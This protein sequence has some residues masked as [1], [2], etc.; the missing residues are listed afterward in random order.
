[1][2]DAIFKQCLDA[3]QSEIQ[4]LSLSDVNNSN[5]VVRKLPWNRNVSK[6]GI[7]IYPIPETIFQSTNA[8]DDVGY[9]VMVILV[10]ASNQNLTS[11]ISRLLTWR[12][13]ISSHFRFQRLSGVSVVYQCL[14]DSQVVFSPGDFLKQFDVSAILVRCM[15]RELRS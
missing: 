11:N 8:S 3:V 5:I 7:F 6:P 1:M 9:G 13:L 12:R 10:Q 15:A 2:A 14:V 4:G